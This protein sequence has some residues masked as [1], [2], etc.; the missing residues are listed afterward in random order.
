[1]DKISYRE[2]F[3]STFTNHE[4]GF[5]TPKHEKQK[6]HRK[7]CP[8]ILKENGMTYL[9]DIIRSESSVEN[10]PTQKLVINICNVLHLFNTYME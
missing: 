6:V 10:L 1:M 5:L 8:K 3:K 9:L 7:I 4:G 2:C